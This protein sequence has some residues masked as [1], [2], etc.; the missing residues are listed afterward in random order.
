MFEAGVRIEDF[1]EIEVFRQ[2][3]RQT[4]RLPQASDAVLPF[5]QLHCLR[6]FQCI[7]AGTSV[8]V[9]DPE[10]RGFFAQILCDVHEDQVF[11]YVGVV[12]GVVGVAVTEHGASILPAMPLTESFFILFLGAA[13][14]YGLATLKARETGMQA[15]R[16]ACREE[17][18][19]LLDETVVGRFRG[20]ARDADGQLRIRRHYSFEFSDT[21]DNRRAGSLALLGQEVEWLHL[22]MPLYLVPPVRRTP[23]EASHQ[24]TANPNSSDES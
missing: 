11:E 4:A 17:G 14:W 12:A 9:D 15:A 3:W 24:A 21:G 16:A 23:S 18:V 1:D 8:G 20:F 2:R 13:I 6:R 5:G 10:R 19:Q 7:E 22:H